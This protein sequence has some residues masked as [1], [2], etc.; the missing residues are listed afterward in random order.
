[1]EIIESAGRALSLKLYPGICLT[2]EGKARKNLRQG[3]SNI[4]PTGKQPYSYN[5][6]SSVHYPT[7]S[8]IS[9]HCF[10]YY[11]Y[12]PTGNGVQIQGDTKK[13][14]TSEMLSGSHVQLAALR[15]RDLELQTTSLKRQV[16]MVQFLSINFFLLDFFNFCW[17]FQKFPFFVS[18]C[19]T[20]LAELSSSGNVSS[21]LWRG[22]IPP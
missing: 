19:I 4:A 9:L 22:R 3:T 21:E 15:N 20:S 13:T 18:P 14:G 10:M 7:M 12:M 11:C 17:G 2:T 16:V 5:I 6:C 1:M 8:P